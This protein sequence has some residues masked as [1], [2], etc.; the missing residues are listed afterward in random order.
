[1]EDAQGPEVLKHKSHNKVWSDEDKYELVAQV[2]AGRPREAVA[3]EAG[4]L[5]RID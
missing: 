4:S 2:L 1:M 3:L 5:S